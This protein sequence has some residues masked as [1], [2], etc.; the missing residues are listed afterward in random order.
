MDV[1]TVSCGAETRDKLAEFRDGHD[2]SNYDEAL[3][4]LLSKVN[5]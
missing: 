3:R 2:Y 1:T 4:A 5:K